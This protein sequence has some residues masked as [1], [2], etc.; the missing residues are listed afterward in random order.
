MQFYGKCLIVVADGE[1]GR[2]FEERRRGGPLT[3]Q[4]SWVEDLKPVDVGAP[5]KGRVFERF[6][7]GS[8]TVEAV[9]PKERSEIRFLESLAARVDRLIV[10]ERFDEVI[11]IAPPR[12]LGTLRASLPH[13]SLKR[14]GP[15]EAAE[16]CGETPAA[17]RTAVR[18]L[19]SQP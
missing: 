8:H 12:A 14:L 9:S 18:S 15:S 10:T 6:G 16:R 2:L 11:L 4:S 13:A 17:I 5:A 7:K 1:N 19:R 3:E